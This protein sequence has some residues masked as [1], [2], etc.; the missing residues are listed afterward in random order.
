M[1]TTFWLSPQAM[2]WYSLQ[3][4]RL[5]ACEILESLIAMGIS[6]EVVDA[7]RW[8]APDSEKIKPQIKVETLEKS[9][10][11]AADWVIPHK[12]LLG[13]LIQAAKNQ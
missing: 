13:V 7:S 2:E 3:N 10:K 4:Q 9:K 11:I 1:A 12:M 8:I 5:S 6:H